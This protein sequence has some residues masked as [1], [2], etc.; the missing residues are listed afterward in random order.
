MELNE[1]IYRQGRRKNKKNPDGY[2]Y[3]VNDRVFKSKEG[4]FQ[5]GESLINKGKQFRVF[6]PKTGTYKNYDSRSDYV[7]FLQ[8]NPSQNVMVD[9]K[10]KR[11]T[12]SEYN[13]F[14]KKQDA[15]LKKMK[16]A[17][18]DSIKAEQERVA[19]IAKRN[20]LTIQKDIEKL[21]E[22]LFDLGD[23][24]PT[25]KRIYQKKIAELKQKLKEYDETI[26]KPKI[27]F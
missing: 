9:G 8:A 23:T 21:E 19:D 12:K 6:D 5:Y 17:E 3:I 4:A 26:P 24:K 11:M 18:A 20:P 25:L 27:E 1:I 10:M 22:E 7:K 13:Q 14:V 16:K 2:E 15:E